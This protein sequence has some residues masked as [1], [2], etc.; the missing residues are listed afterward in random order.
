MTLEPHFWRIA[1]GKEIGMI[2]D[3]LPSEMESVWRKGYSILF[4]KGAVTSP[5][6]QTV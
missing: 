1:K 5:W 2:N 6:W 4:G 3:Y